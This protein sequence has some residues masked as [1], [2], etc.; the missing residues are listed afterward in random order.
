[1]ICGMNSP[2]EIRAKSLKNNN[3]INQKKN[4]LWDQEI[5]QKFLLKLQQ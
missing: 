3:K 5:K 4:K 2:P 1:M